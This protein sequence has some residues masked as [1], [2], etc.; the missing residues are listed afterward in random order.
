MAMQHLLVQDLKAKLVR[1]LPTATAAPNPGLQTNGP[2]AANV[3]V[4][5]QTAEDL[6]SLQIE[7]LNAERRARK[8]DE[9]LQRTKTAASA[10]LSEER[11]RWEEQLAQKVRQDTVIA[12]ACQ[13]LME[14]M[15]S[16]G[17]DATLE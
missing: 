12:M 5:G 6:A 16:G 7:L 2:S 13:P 10:Q 14:G 4:P 3:L 9:E 17:V 1:A 11:R 15:A 8:L